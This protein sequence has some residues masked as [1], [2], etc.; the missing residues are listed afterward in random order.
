MKPIK[1]RRSNSH[2]RRVLDIRRSNASGSHG[3]LK[4]YQRKPKYGKQIWLRGSEWN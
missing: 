3:S 2:Q 4:D 1:S